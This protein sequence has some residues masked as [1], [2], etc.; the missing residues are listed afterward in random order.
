M[1][2]PHCNKEI[3]DNLIAKHLAS[4]GGKESAKNMTKQQRSERASNAVN[5]R[6][7]K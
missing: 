2:C 3:D 1:N 5:K 4:K 7:S 6:W